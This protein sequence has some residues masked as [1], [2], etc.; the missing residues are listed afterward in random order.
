[1]TSRTILLDTDKVSVPLERLKEQISEIL[2]QKANYIDLGNKLIFTMFIHVF[3]LFHFKSELKDKTLE[4]HISFS[5]G[6]LS[7]K[8]GR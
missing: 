2:A 8:H 6:F 5:R 4:M 3:I 1:M 7:T